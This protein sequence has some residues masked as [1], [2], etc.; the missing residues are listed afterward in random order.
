MKDKIAGTSRCRVGFIERLEMVDNILKRVR[1]RE[2]NPGERPHE[3]EQESPEAD[4]AVQ[5]PVE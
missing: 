2:V 3:N 1:K 5:V 4:G